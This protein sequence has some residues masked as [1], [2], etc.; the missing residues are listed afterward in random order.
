MNLVTMCSGTRNA[1]RRVGETGWRMNLLLD[2]SWDLH[3][4]FEFWLFLHG[5]MGAHSE[6]GVYSKG[7][8]GRLVWYGSRDYTRSV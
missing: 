8:R 5:G 7:V 2:F 1:L 4:L 3:C 6:V